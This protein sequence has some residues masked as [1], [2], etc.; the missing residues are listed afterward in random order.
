MRTRA[1]SRP[2]PPIRAIFIRLLRI[3]LADLL[4]TTF[5]SHAGRAPLAGLA[6]LGLFARP[7]NT[8][9]LR[10]ELLLI[11]SLAGS[12][13]FLPFFI[14]PRYLAGILIPAL[15]WIGGGTAWLGDWLAETWGHVRAESG[16]A[17]GARGGGSRG[18]EERGRR[19]RPSASYVVP[20][21]LL[22]LGFFG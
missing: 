6:V 1:C 10:A 20:A 13:S 3:N 5:S 9:R 18:A 12:L 15:V 22:A 4:A 11:A 8:R 14:Q 21:L 19:Q 7:W 16:G 2:S 17:S